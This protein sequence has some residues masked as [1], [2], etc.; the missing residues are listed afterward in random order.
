MESPGQTGLQAQ[1]LVSSSGGYSAKYQE[2]TLQRTGQT[3]GDYE[4]M[5]KCSVSR[6]CGIL[7][8]LLEFLGL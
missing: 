1:G 6:T 8:L 3:T 5:R 7:K 4:T 2:K